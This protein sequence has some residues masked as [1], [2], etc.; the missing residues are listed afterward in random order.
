MLR[1]IDHEGGSDQVNITIDNTPPDSDIRI[2]GTVRVGSTISYTG[3]WSDNLSGPV[4]VK[5]AWLYGDT[6]TDT[7]N[8]VKIKDLTISET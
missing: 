5:E 6:D 7:S 1:I 2:F 4:I 8:A 3:S